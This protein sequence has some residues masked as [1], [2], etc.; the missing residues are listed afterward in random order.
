MAP[1]ANHTAS[2][3][4]AAPLAEAGLLLRPLRDPQLWALLLSVALG[5]ALAAQLPLRYAVDVGREDGQGSDLPLVSG[6]YPGEDSA[7][8]SFRWSGPAAALTLP[9]IGGRAALL[10]LRTIPVSEQVARRGPQSFQLSL[11]GRGLASV[12]LR[13]GGAVYH[14]LLPPSAS[15]DLRVGLASA[16]FVPDDDQRSIGFGLN[17]VLLTAPAGPTMPAPIV[18]GA[19]LALALAWLA[20]RRAGWCAD[21]ALLSLLPLGACLALVAALDAPRLA[22]GI[23]AALVAAALGLW[24]VALLCAAPVAL[25]WLAALLGLAGLAAEAVSPAGGA[26]LL[27]A[28]VIALAAAWLRPAIAAVYARRA[29]P[30]APDAW[31][32]LVSL[33]WLVLLLR[34]G[35]KIYPFSMPGDIGFHVNRFADVLRGDV[36]LVSRNRGVEFPYPPAFYLLLAPAQLLGVTRQ[37]A[38][39][40]TSAL[41]DALSP[42]LVYTIAV[43]GRGSGHH[44]SAERVGLVAAAIYALAPAGQMTTWWNFSTHIFAQFAHLLLLAAAVWYAGGRS[45]GREKA[46]WLWGAALVLQS[47]VYLG[48]FGFWMNT[49]LLAGLLALA[50]LWRARRTGAWADLW[51]FVAAVALAQLVAIGLFYSAY[52]GLFIDQLRAT[53]GGGLTGLA[54]R[55]PVGRDVLWA[56]LWDVGAVVHF[57]F[58]PL[59]LALAGL[60][61]ARRAAAHTWLARGTWLIAA[62]FAALPFL[63]QSTLSSR[64]L[65]FSAWAVA[66]G[67]AEVALRLWRR[68]PAARLV[69]LAC[70]AFVIWLSASMWL[71]AL[72]WRVRP[73]EPF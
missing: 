31:R 19:L 23:P 5:L 63:T 68:G 45:V 43:S 18:F 61:L 15:G 57:G 53:A 26:V 21:G 33:A 28:A 32:A 22:I 51:R 1:A 46:G 69:L 40:L 13:P 16:T 73:P 25:R 8:G 50:L 72:A 49:S 41:L 39:R 35:G 29:A 24:L 17:D 30:I 56:T 62:G 3:R 70:A 48:H 38:L 58:F 65:M 2:H 34:Y 11:G 44:R 47:L 36:L 14:I 27:A 20:L 60:W 9:G 59:A 37:D 4:A 71:G 10:T 64:W 6:F 54:G 42:L 66:A 55:A 52:A 7:F 67:G 12:P